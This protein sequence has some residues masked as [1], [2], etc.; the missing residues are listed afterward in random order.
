M[1]AGGEVVR[2]SGAERNYA[3]DPPHEHTI[4]DL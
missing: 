3:A 2:P 1:Q 4:N